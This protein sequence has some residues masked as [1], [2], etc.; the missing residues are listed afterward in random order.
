[1]FDKSPRLHFLGIC[2]YNANKAEIHFVED[3]MFGPRCPPWEPTLVLHVILV[4][5]FALNANGDQGVL[6]SVT[7]R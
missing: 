1:M 3:W 6:L 4:F 5:V 7:L 2:R